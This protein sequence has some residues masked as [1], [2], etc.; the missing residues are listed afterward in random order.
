[1]GTYMTKSELS[2]D[3]VNSQQDVH[4]LV[5]L[6]SLHHWWIEWLEIILEVRWCRHCTRKP[7]GQ[8]DCA[9]LFHWDCA[10]KAMSLWVKWIHYRSLNGLKPTAQQG[11]P[12]IEVSFNHSPVSILWLTQNSHCCHFSAAPLNSSPGPCLPLHGQLSA[13]G[14]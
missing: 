4:H 10:F 8:R 1:M 3:Q 13:S 9:Q 6:C 7:R 11:S 12:C 2:L 14:T 5:H